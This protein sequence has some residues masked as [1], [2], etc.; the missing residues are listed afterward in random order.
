MPE[1]TNKPSATTF[2]VGQTVYIPHLGANTIP[3]AAVIERTESVV[4]DAN[5]DG[6][7]EQTNIYYFVGGGLNFLPES[8]VFANKD[9]LETYLDNLIDAA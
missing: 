8:K 2:Q 5:N 7:G 3:Q 1:V 9:A 6:T 4:V